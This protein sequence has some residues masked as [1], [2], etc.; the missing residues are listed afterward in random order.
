MMELTAGSVDIH[1]A[2]MCV[3]RL[4]VG[5]WCVREERNLVV[6]WHWLTPAERAFVLTVDRWII[7][8]KRL[9][10]LL[11]L[12]FIIVTSLAI[13]I[14]K[15]NETCLV[16]LPCKTSSA[17]G[18]DAST[19][20]LHLKHHRFVNVRYHSNGWYLI[21][22]NNTLE[23][24]PLHLSMR[25]VPGGLGRRGDFWPRPKPLRSIYIGDMIVV[26]GSDTCRM[27]WRN[28]LN[29]RVLCKANARI[30]RMQKRGEEDSHH[31][32]MNYCFNGTFYWL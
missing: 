5:G 30:V 4:A 18:I 16:A 24:N 20:T 19:S 1:I 10:L 28:K 17:S 32:L 7:V 27:L 23:L 13:L 11:S 3:V 14:I 26:L 12:L 15:T 8:S 21:R 6:G 25:C 29:A 22:F 31:L 9:D 2:Y